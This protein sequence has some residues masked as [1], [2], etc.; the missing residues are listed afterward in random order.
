MADQ[1]KY[2]YIV[3]EK[4][5][6]AASYDRSWKIGAHHASVIA[7]FNT[8]LAEVAVLDTQ[9][10]GKVVLLDGE[11]QSSQADQ[12]FYHQALCRPARL[13]AEGE[14]KRVLVLGGGELCTIKEVLQ[15]PNIEH[16]DMVD[17]DQ[18]FVEFAKRRLRDWHGDSY[19]DPRVKIHYADAWAWTAGAATE[20]QLY[21]SIVVDLTDLSLDN[22][23]WSKEIDRWSILMENLVRLLRPNGSMTVYTGMWIPWKGDAMRA[24]YGNMKAVLRRNGRKEVLQPYRV[25]VPSF[26]CGEAFFLAIGA[27]SIKRAITD[28]NWAA[29]EFP[30]IHGAD[31]AFGPEEALRAVTWG[32]ADDSDWKLPE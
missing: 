7:K 17:Y 16:V 3:L 27:K 9:D 5:A 12:A 31:M 8:R 4:D 30:V 22:D 25:L 26:G 13:I 11:I 28:G 18:T 6:N 1:Y 32:S 10:F 24:A 20:R 15:W 2:D 14:I 29:A 21:D 23:V 19:K